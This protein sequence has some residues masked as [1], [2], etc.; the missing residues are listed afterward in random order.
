MQITIFNIVYDDS[1]TFTC[2]NIE[3]GRK[4]VKE[5]NSIR[6]WKDDDCYSEV[7]D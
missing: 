6:G 3:D 4:I 2:N 5:Q 7:Q 1:Y